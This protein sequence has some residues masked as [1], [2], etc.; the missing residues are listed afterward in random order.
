M[1]Q[2]GPLSL[3]PKSV[4]YINEHVFVPAMD[5]P[6]TL[7]LLIATLL[8]VALVTPTGLAVER[9]G[10]TAILTWDDVN[11]GEDGYWIYR[12]G[13]RHAQVP[14]DTTRFEDDISDGRRHTY[15]VSAFSG[16]SESPLTYEVNIRATG[17]SNRLI[18]I[19]LP[20]LVLVIVVAIVLGRHSSRMNDELPEE[21]Q[22][23]PVL[24]S[25]RLKKV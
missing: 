15:M 21:E 1:V 12:D 4:K 23:I 24:L 8:A 16:D 5:T 19:A 6:I 10:S 2:R 13:A 20:L 22:D 3:N 11:T 25:D 9:E 18:Y 17:A 7:P 14:A